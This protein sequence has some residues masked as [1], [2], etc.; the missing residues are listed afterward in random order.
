MSCSIYVFIAH[1]TYLNPLVMCSD[2]RLTNHHP[3]VIIRSCP[4]SFNQCWVVTLF[5]PFSK[6]KIK[7]VFI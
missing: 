7:I 1:L 4:Q 3:R 2:F 6:I 5:V